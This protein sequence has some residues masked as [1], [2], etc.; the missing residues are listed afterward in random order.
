MVKASVII[1][2]IILFFIFLVFRDEVGANSD[3]WLIVFHAPARPTA[4]SVDVIVLAHSRFGPG[5]SF[6][7][8]SSSELSWMLPMTSKNP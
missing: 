5:H 6:V 4:T 2:G 8:L 1:K 3:A 7:G